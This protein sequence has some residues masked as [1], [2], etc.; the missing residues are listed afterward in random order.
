MEVIITYEQ[1]GEHGRVSVH[2]ADY[3]TARDEA[4][5]LVPEDAQRLNIRVNY[6]Q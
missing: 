4:F 2:H 1:D 3:Y 6:D 5:K